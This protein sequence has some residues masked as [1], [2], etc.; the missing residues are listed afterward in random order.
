MKEITARADEALKA[1]VEP[2]LADIDRANADNKPDDAAAARKAMT[3]ATDAYADP[4]AAQL[5]DL[6]LLGG[7]LLR[8]SNLSEF[9]ERSVKMME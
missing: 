5:V 6:A 2:L 4:R 1:T 9:I 3:E 8:G 7:G